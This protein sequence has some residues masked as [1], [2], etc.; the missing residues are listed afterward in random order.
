MPSLN[1]S[2]LLFLIGINGR[3]CA[4]DYSIELAQRGIFSKID[5]PQ[6]YLCELFRWLTIRELPFRVCQDSIKIERL[7]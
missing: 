5:V 4:V 2:G 3:F 1:Q 6:Q 7:R